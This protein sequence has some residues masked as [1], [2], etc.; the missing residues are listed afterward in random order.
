MGWKFIHFTQGRVY[1]GWGAVRILGTEEMEV[2]VSRDGFF[3]AAVMYATN[4]HQM[5]DTSSRWNIL[6][7][8]VA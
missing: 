7:T 1:R 2:E 5:G 8:K 6:I 4:L 3:N